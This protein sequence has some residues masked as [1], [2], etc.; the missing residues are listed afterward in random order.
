VHEG[1]TSKR[2]ADVWKDVFESFVVVLLY[3][4]LI[5]LLFIRVIPACSRP[6]KRIVGHLWYF[7][8]GG[9]MDGFNFLLFYSK[10]LAIDECP[11]LE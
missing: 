10:S 11:E 1:L 4:T 3:A 5:I 2:V 6:R 9:F 7:F 8:R